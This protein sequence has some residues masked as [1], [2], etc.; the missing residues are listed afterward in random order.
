MVVARSWRPP[1]G[2]VNKSK[3][4]VIAQL[5][6]G[7]GTIMVGSVQDSA[8]ADADADAVYARAKA[9]KAEI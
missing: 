6:F 1:G 5:S 3:A 9:A 7:N 2:L 4:T 8:F